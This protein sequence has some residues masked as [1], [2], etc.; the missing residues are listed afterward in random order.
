MRAQRRRLLG[1]QG[2]RKANRPDLIEKYGYDT[3]YAGHAIRLGLQGI[4]IGTTGRLTLPLAESQRQTC[5]DIRYGKVALEDVVSMAD[6][7]EA[8]LLALCESSNLPP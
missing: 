5:L 7:L 1:E 2:G 6:D 4:E 3:K 8:Q